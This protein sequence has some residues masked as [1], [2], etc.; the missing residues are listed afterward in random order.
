MAILI[1]NTE[2]KLREA[3]SQDDI[4]KAFENTTLRKLNPLIDIIVND[5]IILYSTTGTVIN[6]QNYRNQLESIILQAY[7]KTNNEFSSSFQSDLIDQ[8]S[9]AKTE[10]RKNKLNKI[11]E[12]RNNAEPVILSSL[13]L[14]NLTNAPKQSRLIS[15]TWS[16]IINKNIDAA[17][18]E[19]IVNNL[20]VDNATI[21]DKTKNPLKDELKTHNGVIAQQEIQTATENA[22][23][24][25][26]S[27]I[28]KS[29]ETETEIAER[30]DKTWVTMGDSKVRDKH[31]AANNQRRKL[32]DAFIVGG[33]LLKYPKD[34][35]LGASLANVINCRCKS[36]Y[37]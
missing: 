12:I 1:K 32:N 13:I 27:E 6:I 34:T 4:D 30:I 25:E 36:I 3:M 23:F 20:P 21:A 9:K 15:E 26:V 2:D 16:K 29:L 7:R 24:T 22:K 33:E 28:D 35:S 37:Q 5:F 11:L 18:A 19:N 14:W 8:Y 17:L 31:K 10:S